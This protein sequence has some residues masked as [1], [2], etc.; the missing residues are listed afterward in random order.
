MRYQLPIEAGYAFSRLFS[1]RSDEA[2]RNAE[3]LSLM[4]NAPFI[5]PGELSRLFVPTLVVAGTHDMIKESHTRLIASLLS[6]SRLEIL[7]GDHFV[8]AKRPEEFN[9]VVASFLT[10]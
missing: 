4:V 8:A 6:N 10:D 7:D 5:D 9:R 2:K 1:K 3:L